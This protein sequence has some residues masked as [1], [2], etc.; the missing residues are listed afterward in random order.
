MDTWEPKSTA[1]PAEVEHLRRENARLAAR[2]EVLERQA[3]IRG[4]GELARMEES[5]RISETRF[6]TIVEQSPVS[7]QILSPDGRTLLVNKAWETLW[8][9]TLDQ[10]PEYNILEDQQLVAKGLMPLI[11][12]AFAGEPVTIPPSSYDPDATIPGR[13]RNRDPERWVRGVLYPLKDAHGDV[14]EVVLLHE[15][16]T[17]Q[18]RAQ[19]ALEESEAHLR[20]I[21]D[22]STALIYLKDRAG[23]HLLA[24]RGFMAA[25]HLTD[26]VVGRTDHDLFPPEVADAFR[27]HD[28]QVLQEGQ[29]REWEETVPQEDGLHTYIS[30]KFPLFDTAGRPIATCGIST[31]I[32]ARKRVEQGQRLLAEASRVLASSLDYTTTLANV[33][34]LAVPAFADWCAVRLLDEEGIPRQLALAH[35]DPHRRALA[36]EME[37]RYPTTRESARPDMVALRTGGTHVV[38][39][40]TPEDLASV[41]QDERHL[42]MLRE[43]APRSLL[44]VPLITHGQP[45]GVLTLVTAE[46]GRRYTEADIVLA[47]ELARRASVALENALLYREAQEAIHLRDQFLSVA[48]HEL[49]TPLTALLGNAE[50]LQRRMARDGTLAAR[51]RAM[52]DVI[53]GQARRQRR[54]IEGLLNLSRLEDGQFTL[55]RMPIDL[56]ALVGRVV[57]DLQVGLESREIRYLLPAEALVVQGD[58][59]RLE[60]VVHNLLE[61]A[62]KYSPAGSPVTVR[63]EREGQDAILAITDEG[64]GIPP[65]ALPHIF[66]RFY[67]AAG[68]HQKPISGMGIGLYVVHQVVLRHG[69]SVD[70]DSVVGGGTTVRVRLPLAENL[71]IAPAAG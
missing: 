68:S 17:E 60:Q 51:D 52:L 9:V 56:G 57:E 14:R 47:E 65:E 61:N 7:V 23:R 69:G 71:P 48:S 6:R 18:T 42:A 28:Q 53:V 25:F 15:D 67:R 10:I 58:D 3:E 39:D 2:L 43:L 62:L 5:L 30:L 27:A 41:A 32:T 22:N 37:Q 26:G 24:N 34:H 50:L 20:A 16:V 19:R 35:V 38:T 45:R 11:K 49:K 36:R 33:A 66:E 12:R 44:A 63:V 64:R 54:L 70:V 4:A 13:T 1:V 46:S 8:G 21:L 59:L 40:I 31:D 29:P 55:A